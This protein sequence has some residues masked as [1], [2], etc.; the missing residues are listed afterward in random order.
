MRDN[1][2]FYARLP[3]FAD[4]AEIMDP[5]HYCSLPDDWLIALTDVEHSTRAIDD[6]RYKAVNTAG[7]S[8]RGR[9]ERPLRARFPV[10]LRR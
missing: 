1:A 8:D 3:V 7:A 6:G 5:A 10:R 9:H 2:D 4:F